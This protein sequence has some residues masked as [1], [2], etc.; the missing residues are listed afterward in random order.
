[1]AAIKN[2]V[3]IKQGFSTPNDIYYDNFI[4][5]QEVLEHAG[6][7]LAENDALLSIIMKER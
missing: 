4:N 7:A 5:N 1:M 6:V 3:N 2:Y